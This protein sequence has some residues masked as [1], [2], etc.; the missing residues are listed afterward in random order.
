MLFLS[1]GICS[2]VMEERFPLCLPLFGEVSFSWF[3][4]RI[5]L[6]ILPLV[7]LVASL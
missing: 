3:L 5:E 6:Q 2:E 1:L 4:E 7:N